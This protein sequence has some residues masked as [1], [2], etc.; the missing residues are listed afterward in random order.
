MQT[1]AP[2]R[3]DR[4]LL[5]VNGGVDRTRH[6]L[7]DPC[8]GLTDCHDKIFSLTVK[9]SYWNDWNA[10][11]LTGRASSNLAMLN[12]TSHSE[13]A[14]FV[15]DFAVDPRYSPVPVVLQ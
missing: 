7:V 8:R 6:T 2:Q 13:L 12:Q 5:A 15:L 3:Q 1:S 9:W 14:A 10:L 11:V 4:R